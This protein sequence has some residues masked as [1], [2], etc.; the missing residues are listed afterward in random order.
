M[1]CKSTSIGKRYRK[2]NKVMSIIH[3]KIM[4]ESMNILS[5]CSAFGSPVLVHQSKCS[6]FGLVNQNCFLSCW[7][8]RSTYCSIMAFFRRN[9]QILF[10]LVEA[11]Y[12]SVKGNKSLNVLVVY[13]SFMIKHNKTLMILIIL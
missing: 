1:Q 2:I 12:N 8:K 10:L 6:A 5:K 9:F 13:W 3:Q 11:V 4:I 7:A